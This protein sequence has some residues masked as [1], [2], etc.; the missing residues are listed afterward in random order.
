MQHVVIEKERRQDVRHS[1]FGRLFFKITSPVDQWFPPNGETFE[2]KEM[3]SARI[4][5]AGSSGCCL[6]L[7]RPLEKSQILKI[8]FPLIPETFTIPTLAE[9]RWMRLA[10]DS[11]RYQYQVGVR[12]LL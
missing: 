9:V 2:R 11:E 4:K 5:N 1:F 7:D 12:Y 6:I 3:P 10:P 8:D